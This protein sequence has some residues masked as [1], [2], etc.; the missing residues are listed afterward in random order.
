MSQPIRCPECG[1]EL[2]SGAL[3]GLCPKCLLAAGLESRDEPGQAGSGSQAPTTPH[4]TS[5]APPDAEW[6]AAHFPHLEILELLGHGGMGAVYKARQPKLDRLVALK[7]IRPESADDPAFAERFNREARM[8]ARLSHPHI[9]A[10][11]DF[12][13]VSV[14]EAQSAGSP[15]RLYFFL[16]EYVDGTNLRQLLQ[17]GELLPRQALAIVPQICEALQFAHDEGIVHRDIKPENILLDKRGRVKIADF[18]LAK[19]AA[20]SPQEFTLTGTHQVMGTPRYMAPEQ[21]EGSHAVDHRADIYSLGVVFYEMLTGEVPMGHFEPPSKKVELDVRLDEVVLRSLAREPQRRY[22]HASEVKTEVENIA[23]AGASAFVA[24]ADIKSSGRE[25]TVESAE[26]RAPGIA[27]T[28]VGVIEWIACWAAAG[29]AGLA[30]REQMVTVM[31]SEN[32]MGSL[33]L[34]VLLLGAILSTLVIVAGLTMRRLESWAF[35]MFG[36]VVA[37]LISPGNVIGLPVGIWS[38]YVLTRPEVKTAFLARQR[39]MTGIQG[40]GSAPAMRGGTNDAARQI[41]KP[42][43]GLIITGVISWVTI[44]LAFSVPFTD[45]LKDLNGTQRAIFQISFGV[46]PLVI[47][48]I[49][50]LAGFRMKRLEGY[51]LAIFAAV[52][53]IFV[54]ILKLIGLSFGTLA[55]GPADLVGAPVGLWVL[56]VLTRSD[57]KAAFHGS[58]PEQ[59]SAPRAARDT[60][61]QGW[62]EWWAGRDRRFS[63]TV[64]MML[65]LLFVL[66][67]FMYCGGDG[68]SRLVSPSEGQERRQTF[69]E[70]GRPVPW[71]RCE[72]W[73][74]DQTSFR[75]KFNVPLSVGYWAVGFL[76]SA[77]N[78]RIAKARAQETGEKPGWVGSPMSFTW[79]WVALTLIMVAF[80][81]HP[82]YLA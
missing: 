27:L 7:I 3:G 80:G 4:S 60:L 19:L 28:A 1:A 45:N 82:M 40:D 54:L 67:L 39:R 52:L 29:I 6:L 21:M 68:S 57:V 32:A 56:V 30:F 71:F 16:M 65:L 9:V 73:P 38:I 74:D 63:T 59:V 76:L 24:K 78:W 15:R 2:P 44:P 50:A 70:F 14:L 12:G 51:P 64:Q 81:L 69:A 5:F 42:A 79:F 53:P 48:T 20:S 33:L 41:Q 8:L 13:E 11:Y 31:G 23:S 47:G 10:V 37:M 36:S 49:T 46:V 66:W 55:I 62:N 61:V 43:W 75:W 22:Q 72:S 34:T 35:C 77:V 17:A 26:V 18:G 58:L 25:L